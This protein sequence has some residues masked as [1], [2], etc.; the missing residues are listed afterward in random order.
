MEA[1]SIHP[2]M[3]YKDAHSAIEWL[4]DTWGFEKHL[5]VDGPDDT[6]VHSQL[7]LGEVMVMIG[8]LNEGEYGKLIVQPSDINGRETQA[9]YIVV[10]DPDWFYTKAKDKGAK[11][12]IDIKDEDYG[13]RGFTCADPQGHVWNFGSYDPWEKTE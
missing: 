3:K 1:K 13:G 10:D 6:V 4:C 2:T 9:P 8:S 11:I 5:V 12:L 7:K